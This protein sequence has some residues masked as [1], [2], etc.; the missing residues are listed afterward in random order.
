MPTLKLVGLSGNI[1]A[2][3]KTRAFVASAAVLAAERLH[4]EAEVIEVNDF[5]DQLGRARSLAD[6][7]AAGQALIARIV[8]ADALIVATPIYKA[9]YPGLFKHLIDLLD[10]LSLIGKPVLIAAV[11]GGE[12]HALAVEHQLRPLFGFFEAH[13]LPTAVHISDK[14]FSDG[15]LTAPA[16]IARLARA[17]A[18]FDLHF[19][20]SLRS[21]EAAA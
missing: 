13:T 18:Q 17:V 12:R 14:D 2:P 7:D 20:L 16:A 4:A 6:L 15:V 9:S 21:A 11:G 3:S 19:P 1:T 10:P 8:G 5:G